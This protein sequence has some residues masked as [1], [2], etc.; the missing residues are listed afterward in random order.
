M[1]NT[2]SEIKEFIIKV[3]PEGDLINEQNKN[4]T[5]LSIKGS[6]FSELIINY[7]NQMNKLY[8]IALLN[9][10]AYAKCSEATKQR[11]LGFAATNNK[12][13]KA[14]DELEVRLEN[15]ERCLREIDWM[16]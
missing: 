3:G 5:F 16:N 1:W 9:A 8:T 14:V 7:K 2:I 15:Y 13:L 11:Y 12:E 6:E 4:W 10:A